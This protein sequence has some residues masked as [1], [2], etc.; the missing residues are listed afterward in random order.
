MYRLDRWL[1]NERFNMKTTIWDET[2]VSK[3]KYM[4]NHKI[5]V[6]RPLPEAGQPP[7]GTSTIERLALHR[8]EN[9][10]IPSSTLPRIV[11]ST[12]GQRE[13]RPGPGQGPLR[14]LGHGYCMMFINEMEAALVENGRTQPASLQAT[15]TVS[16]SCSLIWLRFQSKAGSFCG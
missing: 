8:Q 9:S 4:M 14:N 15:E 10:D 7:P 13:P 1:I 12:Q 5:T 3:R 2:V 11:S 6:H 16:Q